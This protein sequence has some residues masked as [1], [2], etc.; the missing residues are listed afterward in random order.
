MFLLE[1]SSGLYEVCS[2]LKGLWVKR[3]DLGWMRLQNRLIFLVDLVWV[4]NGSL[5]VLHTAALSAVS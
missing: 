3:E 5:V 4:S 2:I 1:T